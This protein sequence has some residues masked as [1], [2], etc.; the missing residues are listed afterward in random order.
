MKYLKK[1]AEVLIGKAGGQNQSLSNIDLADYTAMLTMI[2]SYRDGSGEEVSGINVT[3]QHL[4]QMRNAIND[5]LFRTDNNTPVSETGS[6]NNFNFKVETGL[7]EVQT[8]NVFSQVSQQVTQLLQNSNQ[9]KQAQLVI[10][11]RL[12]MVKQLLPKGLNSWVAKLR[13]LSGFKDF[14]IDGKI[15]L[16]IMG[17]SEEEV[18]AKLDTGFN[19]LIM[20]CVDPDL[21]ESRIPD[22]AAQE[23]Q[24][25]V[26]SAQETG[27]KPIRFNLNKVTARK[28]NEKEWK[29][30][31]KSC[32]GCEIA[33]VSALG[34]TETEAKSQLYLKLIPLSADCSFDAN[35][36]ENSKQNNE[37]NDKEA[38]QF[39]LNP[40][41]VMSMKIGVDKWEARTRIFNGISPGLTNLVATGASEEAAREELD[42][43]F[44]DFAGPMTNFIKF[45][46]QA[47]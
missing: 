3:R 7:T 43:K 24:Q 4:E 31:I 34:D 28:I 18:R 23:N 15:E 14:S 47:S 10:D 44:S 33:V 41:R 12:V 6:V 8:L 13:L 30:T 29:A 20:A 22:I 42:K 16:S 39:K 32:D 5:Y 36:P 46:S 25:P 40:S 37:T 19:D 38:T 21:S 35:E 11:P 26:N 45:M 1:S 17:S 9:Q 27:I 2:T